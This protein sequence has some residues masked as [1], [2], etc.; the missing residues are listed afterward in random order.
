MSKKKKGNGQHKEF[1]PRP[2]H[3]EKFERKFP[4]GDPSAADPNSLGRGRVRHWSGR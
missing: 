3:P 4:A 2:W 1:A